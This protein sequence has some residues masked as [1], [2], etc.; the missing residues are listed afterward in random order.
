MSPIAADTVR[1]LA[2]ALPETTEEPHFDITS[3]RVKKKI[4][5]TLN[6]PQ[7]RATLKFSRDMQDIFS[8]IGKGAIYP[9]PNAWGKY[10]WT[11]VDLAH[12]ETELFR[13]ALQVAWRET[14]PAGFRKKYPEQYVDE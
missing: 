11:N 6:P 14:A 1:Q 8:R 7:Q 4:F 5:A 12:V 10:G 13:D 9:V 3:F 2:L